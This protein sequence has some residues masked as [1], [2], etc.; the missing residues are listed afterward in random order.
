MKKLKFVKVYIND[1]NMKFVL[2]K[3]SG[4]TTIYNEQGAQNVTLVTVEPNVVDLVRTEKKDG[5]NAVRL[6]VPKTSNVVCASEFRV[7]GEIELKVNDTVGV[8]VFEVGDV[9]KVSAQSKGKGFQGVVKRHGFKGGPASHGH[10]HVLRAPGSI[11]SAYPQHVLKG[12][13]MAGR[14]G[15]ERATSMNLKVVAVD[16]EKNI[17]ALRGS[18]PGVSGRIVEIVSVS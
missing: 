1:K 10:R 16:V 9:V 11:G 15:G 3:K 2:G 7:E 8:D 13:K 5:Y 4:M 17:I 14:T 12:R 6:S 18:I